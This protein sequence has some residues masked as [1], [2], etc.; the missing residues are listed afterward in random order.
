M[1]AEQVFDGI[2][3]HLTPYRELEFDY[4]ASDMDVVYRRTRPHSWDDLITWLERQGDL[5]NELTP[6][7]VVA[8]V[9]DLRT[10]KQQ[11]V[12][13]I[14]DPQRAFEEAHRHRAANSQQHAQLHE[15]IR[16]TVEQLRH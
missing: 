14:A 5:D 10:L 2:H 16:T 12:P 3:L 6:G 11:G 8:L 1:A 15:R 13:F 7:E 9:E 4:T